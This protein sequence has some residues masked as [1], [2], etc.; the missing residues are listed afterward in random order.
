LKK[1]FYTL[2]FSFS[3]ILVSKTIFATACP[4]TTSS[5]V[6]GQAEIFKVTMTKMELCTGAPLSTEFDVTCTGAVT[7]GTGNMV[8][9]IASVTAGADVGKFLSTAGLPIGTTFTHAKPTFSKEFTIKGAVHIDSNIICVTDSTAT[10]GSNTKYETI[11]AGKKCSATGA[12]TT[13]NMTTCRAEASEQAYHFF[14]SGNVEVCHT[15]STNNCAGSTTQTWNYDLPNDTA[16]YGSSIE[17]T[18]SSSDITSM[19]YALTSPYTVGPT[20][21]KIAVQFG[22]MK[23]LESNKVGNNNRCY[24]GP[25]WPKVNITI[26]D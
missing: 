7:V 24:I 8:F 17:K 6:C 11:M 1:L 20:S 9:D 14:T 15:A 22:V 25:Y 2:F 23:A 12:E 3:F 26:T 5:Q 18:G 10:I 13:A 21:P 16:N 4:S 19:I